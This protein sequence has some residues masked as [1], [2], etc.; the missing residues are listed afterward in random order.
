MIG[1]RAR[2]GFILPS[3][4]VVLEQEAIKILPTGISAH[5]SRARSSDDT[6]DELIRM[7]KEAPEAAKQL[8]DAEVNAIAFTC[9]AASFLEGPEYNKQ[10]ET[11][12][13]ETTGIPAVT[14]SSAIIQA[15]QALGLKKVI[16]ISPYEE[17]LNERAKAFIEA[18]GIE[19]LAMEGL[20]IIDVHIAD[21]SP[22]EVY[23]LARKLLARNHEADGIFISCTDLRSA[24]I[25]DVLERDVGK[26]VLSSNQATLWAMLRIAGLKVPI[27]GFGSLLRN[28]W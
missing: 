27:E 24:E 11:Q 2:L 22:E 21:V 17:W 25:L 10:I 14:T 20:G 3:I 23:Q 16:L 9:T 12:I 18:H 1:W 8:A 6:Y 4:N 5:F 19:V 28:H 13:R 7:G 26:P 15:Q